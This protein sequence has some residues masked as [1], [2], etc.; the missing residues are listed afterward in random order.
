M[1]RSFKDDS[2]Y[3]LQRPAPLSDQQLFIHV[4]GFIEAF[5]SCDH[6]HMSYE[7]PA[8]G[9]GSAP[10]PG[11]PNLLIPALLMLA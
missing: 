7:V 5:I 8:E 2:A 4:S 10:G 6:I 9:S 1:S 3:L 11:G